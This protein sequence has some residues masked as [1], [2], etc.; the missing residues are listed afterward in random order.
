MR[1]ARSRSE[2]NLA[3]A[4]LAR[5][6]GTHDGLDDLVDERILDRHLDPRL[7]HEIDDV[8]AP[9]IELRMTPAAGRNP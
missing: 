2:M 5:T 4:D 9:A 3:I 7:R 6:G 1:M 8:L